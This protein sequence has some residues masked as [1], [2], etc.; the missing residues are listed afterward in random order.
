[1][2]VNFKFVLLSKYSFPKCDLASSR[3]EN[4]P[5]FALGFAGQIL[6]ECRMKM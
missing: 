1:M 2:P 6:V 5:K 3:Y 4:F